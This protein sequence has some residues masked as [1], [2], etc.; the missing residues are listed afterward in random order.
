MDKVFDFFYNGKDMRYKKNDITAIDKICL[1]TSRLL[2][3]VDYHEINNSSIIKEAHVSRSTF[4]IYFKNKEQVLI[5]MYDHIFDHI[6]SKNLY[7][8]NSNYSNNDL[9]DILVRSFY[10][11]LEEGEFIIAVLNSGASSTFLNRL[12]KRLKP[13]ISL[14]IEKKIIGN[15]DIPIDIKI[16]QY[17]NGYT[18]LLQYYLRH[19]ND[20][21][22]EIISEYYLTLYK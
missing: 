16:H 6:F 22:P 2:L 10:H 3:D 7:K 8:E 19:A 14:L 1:A 9:K 5:Y 4:Y 21:K 13:L 18:S 15:N 12:R 11:F 17:I 20:I